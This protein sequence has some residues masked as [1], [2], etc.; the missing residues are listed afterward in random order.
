MSIVISIHAFRVG[1]S[2]DKY[3]FI[4]LFWTATNNIF[5]RYV[6]LLNHSWGMYPKN[7]VL[8]LKHIYL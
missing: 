6:S 7:K 4:K 1:L 2:R 8:L 5:I 3:L